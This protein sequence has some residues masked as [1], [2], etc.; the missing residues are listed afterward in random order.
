MA[1]WPELEQ[2][3]PWENVQRSMEQRILEADSPEIRTAL[4]VA[5]GSQDR[6]SIRFVHDGCFHKRTYGDNRYIP[7]GIIEGWTR[8][9]I[10]TVAGRTHRFYE[11]EPVSDGE[12][13]DFPG[14]D[15]FPEVLKIRGRLRITNTVRGSEGAKQA[16]GAFS[17]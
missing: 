1:D 4:L 10:L 14:W 16:Y 11:V 5:L 7:Q 6:A 9:G 3:G 17:C 12:W 13:V 15:R 8:G 2:E